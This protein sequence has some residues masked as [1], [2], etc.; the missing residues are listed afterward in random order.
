MS[1]GK[2]N[3]VFCAKSQPCN[4]FQLSSNFK[5]SSVHQSV[6]FTILFQFWLG[7]S[8]QLYEL[9][10]WF[11]PQSLCA[12]KIYGCNPK[13]HT[14]HTICSMYPK[15]GNFMHAVPVNKARILACL[16]LRKLP[17]E[18]GK[19]RDDCFLHRWT[20][21]RSLPFTSVARCRTNQ[22]RSEGH[23]K[24]AS[25]LNPKKSDTT[26]FNLPQQ[27]KIKIKIRKTIRKPNEI[28]LTT[29][30]QQPNFEGPWDMTMIED[31][32]KYSLIGC[33][34]R[35]ADKTLSINSIPPNSKT[36]LWSSSSSIIL[37]VL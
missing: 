13:N 24:S 28:W 8:A 32:I 37:N 27:C 18:Q 31:A 25:P 15:R 11:K 1:T 20:R 23:S 34:V 3:K 12:S 26:C 14:C 36:Y 33:F 17:K 10:I 4:Y 22:A 7:R 19:E 29:N 30:K 21:S 2:V 9:P 5:L 16:A 6:T 35:P